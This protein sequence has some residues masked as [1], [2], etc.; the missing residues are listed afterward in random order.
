M[1]TNTVSIR[2]SSTRQLKKIDLRFIIVLA[3]LDGLAPVFAE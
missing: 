3:K 2:G 1:E